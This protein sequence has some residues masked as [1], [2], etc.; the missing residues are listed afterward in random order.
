[1]QYNSHFIK[2]VHVSISHVLLTKSMKT[3]AQGEEDLGSSAAG[4]NL[5][6]V[7]AFMQSSLDPP[8]PP[9]PFLFPL[10]ESCLPL[11]LPIKSAYQY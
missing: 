9:T 7:G 8:P 6:G 3:Y 4:F 1:M 10:V 2:N 5:G 11:N